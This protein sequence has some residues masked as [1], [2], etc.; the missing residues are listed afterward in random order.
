MDCLQFKMVKRIKNPGKIWG[1]VFILFE[2][3]K[4]NTWWRLE[5]MLESVTSII[6]I[7]I[8]SKVKRQMDFCLYCLI[9]VIW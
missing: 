7:F 1:L 8:L 3:E 4:T 6:F 2:Q 9:G 5:E